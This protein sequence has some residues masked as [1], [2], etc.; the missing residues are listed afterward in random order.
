M[1]KYN[2]LRN[3]L[4]KCEKRENGNCKST[5]KVICAQRI[6]EKNIGGDSDALLQLKAQARFGNLD[7]MRN[8]NLALGALFIS[9][10]S[11]YVSIVLAINSDEATKATTLFWYIVIVAFVFIIIMIVNKKLREMSLWNEYMNVA[12]EKLEEKYKK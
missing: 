8:Y 1:D 3:A 4:M 7:Q 6:I 11:I 12:I 10:I 9:F 2:E 5:N